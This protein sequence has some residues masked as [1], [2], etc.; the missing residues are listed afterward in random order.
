[1]TYDFYAPSSAD[2]WE[3]KEI[4]LLL[5]SLHCNVIVK[6]HVYIGSATKVP[7][8]SIEILAESLRSVQEME[9]MIIKH[10]KP[11]LI[12]APRELNICSLFPFAQNTYF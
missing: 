8:D 3:W 6:N 11:N 1:M 7:S 2:N 12:V 9:D 10:N 4:L 5:I